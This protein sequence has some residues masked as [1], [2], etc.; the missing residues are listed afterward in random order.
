[1]TTMQVEKTE[2]ADRKKISVITVVFND[3]TNIEKTMLT[4]LDQTYKNI[5][6]IV[7]DG[8][9]TDGTVGVI[10][11]YSERLAY[12]VSEKDSGIAD[13]MNKG[14]AKATGE[15]TNFINSGDYFLSNTV[16]EQIFSKPHTADLVYGGFISNFG[17]IKVKCLPH[18]DIVTKCYQAMQLVHSTL[19]VKT[20][21]LKK[22]GFNTKYRVSA[23]NEFVVRC[24]SC[25]CSSERVDTLIFEVG[26]TGNSAVHW[27]KAKMENWD[28]AR[29]YYPGLKT[30]WYHGSHIVR[31][32][33]FRF[34]KQL[35]S[36]VG[37]YQLLRWIYRKTI[38]KRLPLLP[39][40][41]IPFE[42]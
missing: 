5:E 16:F 33:S 34:F 13:A 19:F 6:Y 14:V 24:V 35:F 21:Y 11:K 42:K 23:D 1:M 8:G 3:V 30:D 7:I 10:K 15:Y 18:E 25:G 36:Y 31:E 27:L 39:P 26:T 12:W 40:D 4:V 37:F 28:I 38:K 2:L 20:E 41:T 9:S 17:G 22:F 32:A 29:K